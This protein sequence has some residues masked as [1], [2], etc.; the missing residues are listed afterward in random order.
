MKV[1]VEDGET[2]KE[3]VQH[4]TGGTDVRRVV[5]S[6]E[7]VHYDLITMKDRPGDRN[8]A[9]ATMTHQSRPET[10]RPHRAKPDE[11]SATGRDKATVCDIPRGVEG[12]K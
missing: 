5:L 8:R 9:H 1:F 2:Y 12:R 3:V 6:K 11:T 4:S 7:R 10:T